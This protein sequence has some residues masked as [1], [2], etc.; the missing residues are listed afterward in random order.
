MNAEKVSPEKF[1]PCEKN[2]SL[3]RRFQPPRQVRGV[4]KM[5]V[6]CGLVGGTT[7]FHLGFAFRLAYKALPLAPRG[8]VG[9]SP[10]SS[11]TP[12]TQGSADAMRYD[13]NVWGSQL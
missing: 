11:A 12:S 8:F 2:R 3:G 6:D 1:I 7:T 4:P 10:G 5:M 9:F 13:E